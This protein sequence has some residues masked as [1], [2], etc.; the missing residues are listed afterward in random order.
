MS[1]ALLLIVGLFLAPTF[2]Q[3]A[4]AK[5]TTIATKAP[6][7]FEELQQ[8]RLVVL[9]LYF[10]G[11]KRGMV[12]ALIA[13]GTVTFAEPEEVIRLLPDLIDPELVRATIADR[14]LDSN[15]AL[16]CPA[17][18]YTH[19]CGVLDTPTIGV[20]LNE[21]R[22]R[23]DI[24]ISPQLLVTKVPTQA[25]SYLPDPVATPSFISTATAS[26]TNT[27]GAKSDLFLY[28]DLLVSRGRARIEAGL[29]Y[30]TE[31][32]FLAE[33]MVASLDLDRTRAST[34][35][36]R[37]RGT[38][39]LGLPR[40][41]GVAF[42]TQ[43]D[44]RLDRDLLA[45]TPLV[46]F[47][48]ERARV[49]VLLGERLLSAVQLEAGNNVIDT[50]SFPQGTYEVEIVVKSVSGRTERER[51]V[52][53]KTDR[54]PPVGETAFFGNVGFIEKP[55]TGSFGFSDELFVAAGIAR[56]FNDQL[57]LEVR[58]E[59]SNDVVRAEARGILLTAFA[60]AE[61][62]LS[63]GTDG[64]VAALLSVRSTGYS[65]LAY[66]FDLRHAA[67]TSPCCER[68]TENS[69]AP[70]RSPVQLPFSPRGEFTQ[71]SGTLAY[72]ER[73][74]QVGMRGYYRL[75]GQDRNYGLTLDGRYDLVRSDRFTFAAE[76]SLGT[77]S[78]GRLLYAGVTL[79]FF[80]GRLSGAASSGIRTTSGTVEPP[81]DGFQGR[82]EIAFSD[83]WGEGQ[84]FNASAAGQYVGGRTE[85]GLDASFQNRMGVLDGSVLTVDGPT[86]SSRQ[87]NM[88]FRTTLIGGGDGLRLLAAPVTRSALV[89]ETTGARPG[90]S[91]EVLVDDQANA[92]ITGSSDLVLTLPTYR[93]YKVRLRP[94]S[95]GPTAVD[96]AERMVS[97]FPGNVV[98]LQWD[99][100]PMVLVF[101]RLIGPDGTA[102]ADAS[103]RWERGEGR[104]DRE[105]FF[106]LE[107]ARPAM[108]TVVDE[109]GAVYSVEISVP[110]EATDFADV[111]DL[112]L[113][114]TEETL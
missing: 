108:L 103:Y 40:M 80:G 54:V 104:T 41:L 69:L 63:A 38:T 64:S 11:E 48:N 16:L 58:T 44:T 83:S 18:T 39:V 93:Q 1:R 35:I 56:R 8:Q 66:S 28:N 91:F 55:G 53:S 51:R 22:F 7:G 105:G 76:A 45:G 24:F 30:A 85:L 21:S 77:S 15:T 61:G 36:F 23:V 97:L 114:G 73:N 101:G 9:D 109:R 13:P 62:S 50:S 25:G 60:V 74:L 20:I 72:S 111:G 49:E 86:D 88:G 89:V 100:E 6:A 71:A 106:Q 33:Q 90:D 19:D 84:R 2:A 31:T 70:S 10:G 14:P 68:S 43:F 95:T 92:T 3:P 107:I 65:K 29:G 59:F 5:E 98:E 82:G 26:W 67:G 32:G 37:A 79:R 81:Q 46:I 47:L 34:G 75:A 96:I 78:E 12:Q 112:P 99:V 94:K 17:S 102:L 27:E 87:Y 110:H 42:E 57:T 113:K 4:S 52:F